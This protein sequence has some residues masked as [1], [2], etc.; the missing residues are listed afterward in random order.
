MQPDSL[1]QPISALVRTTTALEPWE[2][3]ARAAKLFRETVF[4]R[5][6][7]VEED[8][9]VGVVTQQSL[10]LALAGGA[11]FE[12]PVSLA[13]VTDAPTITPLATGAEALRMMAETGVPE[14]IVVDK[15][16][17]LIGMICAGDLAD[18]GPRYITPPMVG[19][20]ATPFGVYL[21]TGSLRAGASGFALVTTGM[22]L[23]SMLFVTQWTSILLADWLLSQGLSIRWVANIE[24]GL[25]IILFLV[26]IKAIPLSSIH[27]AEHMVVNAIE[28]GEPLQ[29]SIVKRMPRVHPRCGTNVAVGLTLF[30]GISTTPWIPYYEVRVLAGL[31]AAMFLWRPLGGL[32]QL[33]VTTKTPKDRHVAMGIQAGTELLEKFRTTRGRTTVATRIYN[34]GMLHVITGSMLFYGFLQLISW[35]FKI[36]LP[37]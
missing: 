33:L 26:A 17:F 12:E 16:G 24:Q 28:R 8:R 20:M 10:A 14:L 34:S 3:L 9:V 15:D 2:S 22:L 4:D 37:F 18:S 31:M 23:F 30:L 19:G 7:V 36:N 27:A 6:P 35:L 25:P 29:P 5:L 21:T 13:M 32:M 11:I 1:G